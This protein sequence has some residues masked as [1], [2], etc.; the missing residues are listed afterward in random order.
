MPSL[1]KQPAASGYPAERMGDLAGPTVRDD[2]T[3]NAVLVKHATG[4]ERLRLHHEAQVLA[5]ARMPGV[6]ECVGLDEFGERCELHL[7]YVEACTLAELPPLAPLD[8]LDV[9]IETGTTLAD[10]HARGIR[11]GALHADHVLLIPPCRP[12]LCGFGEA[13]GPSDL[14]QHSANDD[15]RALAGLAASEL[16]RSQS[17]SSSTAEQQACIDALMAARSLEIA[18]A[19]GNDGGEPLTEW[20]ARMRRL[21]DIAE[22]APTTAAD[23]SSATRSLASAYASDSGDPR[24]WLRAQVTASSS[25]DTDAASA[26]RRSVRSVPSRRRVV[27]YAAAAAAMALAAVVGWRTLTAN[28]PPAD[29]PVELTPT[30]A[31]QTSARRIADADSGFAYLDDTGETVESRTALTPA[32]SATTGQPARLRTPTRTSPPRCRVPMARRCSMPPNIDHQHRIAW[33]AKAM[34]PATIPTRQANSK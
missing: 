13:T 29:A 9:L 18:S 30:G 21:R 12:V 26:D 27:S 24:A 5:A 16:T 31:A 28:S 25:P 14:S 3:G 15:L 34:P 20:V 32:C 10:L 8:A 23:D 4:P 17:A 11:H 1:Q 6:V 33:P 2:G 19:S 7:R 22:H